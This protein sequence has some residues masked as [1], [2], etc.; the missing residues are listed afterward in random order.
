MCLLHGCVCAVSACL[1]VKRHGGGSVPRAN[2][3]AIARQN[4]NLA[5][6]L[7]ESEK[8]SPACVYVE[9]PPE[10]TRRFSDTN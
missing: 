2:K 7:A 5:L 10:C 1:A 6:E 3:V 9:P 8:F 4:K